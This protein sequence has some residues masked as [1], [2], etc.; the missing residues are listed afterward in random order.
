MIYSIMVNNT[1]GKFPK[2]MKLRL[3]LFLNFL[4]A[5]HWTTAYSSGLI[6]LMTSPKFDQ[7]IRSFEDI[8]K[9]K[10]GFG[11]TLPTTRLFENTNDRFD[12]EVTLLVN[13][14]FELCQSTS[15][16]LEKI[17]DEK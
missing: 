11:M 1:I 14:N 10:F 3:F 4:Y 5:L 7:Q 8:L 17:A 9:Y 2:S 12:D 16:C 6:S 15:E 13:K